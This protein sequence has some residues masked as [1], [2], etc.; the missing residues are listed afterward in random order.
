V[1]RAQFINHAFFDDG[2][3]LPEVQSV[4]RDITE[5]KRLEARLTGSLNELRDLYQYAPCAC[6]PLSD[7]GTILH[8]NETGLEWLGRTREAIIGKL[9]LPDVPAPE[10]KVLF[11]ETF[12]MLKASGSIGNLDFDL[13][14]LDAEL[15]RVSTSATA[16]TGPDG[17]FTMSRSVMFDITELSDAC[18][19]LRQLACEQDAML[20][21]DLVAILKLRERRII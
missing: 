20:D 12:Q 1:R 6:F 4:G 2:G 21:N 15:R 5:R 17:K 13:V 10:G 7:D 18:H 11:G 14:T 16:V 3:A 19:A 9:K 8:M